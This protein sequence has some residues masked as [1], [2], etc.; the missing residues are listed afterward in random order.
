[1]ALPEYI[2]ISDN[3]GADLRSFLDNRSYTT[4]ALLTDQHTARH[5]YPLIAQRLPQHTHITIPAGEAHKTLDT[6]AAVWKQMTEAGIDRKSVLIVLGGGMPGDLG[7]FCAATYKR[8]IDFI[9]VPTTLL[10]QA[11][12]SIGGKLG[13]DFHS[14]KNHIGVFRQPALTLLSAVF[15]NTLPETE[16]RSGFAEIL[17][18]ALISDRDWWQT[19]IEKPWQDQNW[20]AE[21]ERSARLKWSIVSEDPNEKGKRKILNAGHTLGHAIESWFLARKEPILHGEAVA[22]GLIAESFIAR[23]AGLLSTDQSRQITDYLL[24]TFG[25]LQ[26]NS[27]ETPQIGFLCYQDKKNEGKKIRMALLKE[28]GQAVWDYETT[29]EHI[30]NAL[31]EYRQL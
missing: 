31:E 23:N 20:Q 9:L 16:L 1:M 12:A 10:A 15:L 28:I 4:V 22:A 30:L 27:T 3:P 5:C 25:K 18:H 29:P 13:I 24:Q 19:L 17:K 6:C 26:W 11:D 7:G 14:Y 2:R 21:I 8:G